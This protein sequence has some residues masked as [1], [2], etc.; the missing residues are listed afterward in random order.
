LCRLY[1]ELCSGLAL[2]QVDQDRAKIDF[3]EFL[4][5]DVHE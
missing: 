1:Y 5:H 2:G 4:F 3:R